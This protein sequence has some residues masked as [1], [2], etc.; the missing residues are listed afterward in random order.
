MIQEP[1]LS[2]KMRRLGNTVPDQ[3]TVEC[4]GNAKGQPDVR[5]KPGAIRSAQ[6]FFRVPFSKPRQLIL[7]RGVAG[8]WFLCSRRF[9]G[10]YR[11]RRKPFSCDSSKYGRYLEQLGISY[12]TVR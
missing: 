6:P 10:P 8:V 5:K 4:D 11:D 9:Q 12:P 2:K 3:P 7:R 1:P